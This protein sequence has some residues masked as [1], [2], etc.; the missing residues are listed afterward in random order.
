MHVAGCNVGG[1]LIDKGQPF[2]RKESG[3]VIVVELEVVG[4][5]VRNELVNGFKS[6]YDGAALCLLKKLIG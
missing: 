1:G 2:G 3:Q 5:Y 4:K 6:C